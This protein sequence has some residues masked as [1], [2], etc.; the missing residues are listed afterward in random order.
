MHKPII[1]ISFRR[2]GTHLLL[3]T[4]KSNFNYPIINDVFHPGFDLHTSAIIRANFIPIYIYRDPHDVMKSLYNFFKYSAWRIWSGF[5]ADLSGV[6][7]SDFLFGN[8]KIL[9]V[10]CPHF[11]LIFESPILA[12]K[13]HTNWLL[14]LNKHDFKGSIL[15][16]KYED[17]INNPVK[18]VNSLAEKLDINLKHNKPIP[19]VHRVSQND[20]KDDLVFR[21]E[22][23]ELLLSIAKDKMEELGYL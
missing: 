13:E 21:I 3:E 7:F 10:F 22:D 20:A 18:E 14:P 12:W 9:N 1:L 15:S 5:D 4:L 11:K 17:L 8:T 19:Y 6:S 16:V 23:E 2:S